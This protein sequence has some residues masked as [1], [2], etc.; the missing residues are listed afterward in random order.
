M[1]WK[2]PNK[3][4]FP[5]NES[6]YTTLDVYGHTKTEYEIVTPKLKNYRVAI[7]VGAHIGS[8]AIRYAKDFSIVH[9]FEPLYFEELNCNIKGI[10]N[11]HSYKVAIS[12]KTSEKFMKRHKTNSG[13]SIII[14]D[15]T[16][17]YLEKRSNWFLSKTFSVQSIPLDKF[18][19]IEVDFIKIDT[20]NYVFPIIVGA[21][22]TLKNNS[23]ILQIELTQHI[24]KVENLL[25]SFGY[26][27]Y[28]TFSVDRFYCKT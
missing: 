20:E 26:E 2:L 3:W 27:C 11:I 10:S 17:P 13:M 9:A 15:D 25:E 7:D 18:S 12:D 23:P 28:A 8:T 5:P 24:E 22:N 19:F 6:F 21:E 1:T 14:D 4:I 16:T